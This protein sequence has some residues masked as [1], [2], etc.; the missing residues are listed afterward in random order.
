M[1]IPEQ[2]NA[3]IQKEIQSLVLAKEMSYM[4]AILFLC[5]KYSIEPEL[6]A[7]CLSKPIIQQLKEEGENLNLLPKSQKL[8]L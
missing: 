2:D 1:I 6:M 5:E 8:K 3:K 4:D 7:K